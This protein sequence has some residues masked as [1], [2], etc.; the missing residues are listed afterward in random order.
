MRSSRIGRLRLGLAIAIP[1]A[2]LLVTAPARA[3]QNRRGAPPPAAAQP[4]AEAVTVYLSPAA[5]RQVQLALKAAGFAPDRT[6]GLWGDGTAKALKQF[7][8]KKGLDLSGHAN[9]MTLTALGLSPLLDGEA[10]A[11]A[12]EPLS[13]EAIAAGG[14]PLYIS[15]ASV[16]K[17]QIGLQ[18]KAL[19]AKSTTIP[20]N[21]LGVWHAGSEKAASEFQK[22]QG[23]AE[24]GTPDL[25]AIHALGLDAMLSHPSPENVLMLTDDQAPFAGAE[26]QV[27]PALVQVIQQ[28]LEKRGAQPGAADGR[29][30]KDTAEAVRRFQQAQGLTVT[31]N[32]NLETL[33]ALG[34][35]HPLPDLA[36]ARPQS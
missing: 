2:V 6:D 4:A 19:Q 3:G 15:P 26:V 5:V 27:G 33:R 16:R 20:G 23:L 30:T 31:G 12:G 10:A 17:I 14:T 29:W 28:A 24:T 11:Q 1:A 25:E 18:Q 36:Q 22:T 32:L 13:K 34:F 21:I 8:D 9:L 7:Q 35:S